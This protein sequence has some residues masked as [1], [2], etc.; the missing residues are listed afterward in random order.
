MPLSRE[1]FDDIMH[2]MA[3]ASDSA[4]EYHDQT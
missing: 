1:E 2:S 4:G 3:G